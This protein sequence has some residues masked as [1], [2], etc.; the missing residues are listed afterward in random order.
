MV[1]HGYHTRLAARRRRAEARLRDFFS[2]ARARR[3]LL[4]E[5]DPITLSPVEPPLFVHVDLDTGQQTC[6]SAGVLAQY[7]L[8]SGDFRNPLTRKPLTRADLLRLQHAS[9]EPVFDEL[10]LSEARRKARQEREDLLQWLEGEAMEQ[11]DALV[12]ELGRARG[13]LSFFR[14]TAHFL[15]MLSAGVERVRAQCDERGAELCERAAQAIAS[16][17]P[18]SALREVCL[19]HVRGMAEEARAGRRVDLLPVSTRGPSRLPP[20]S[21]FSLLLE[22]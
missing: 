2:A 17:P 6:F 19:G 11:V 10:E 3:A 22:E 8:E 15:P 18:T 7:V 20:S 16:D 9:G 5:T 14:I 13:G 1:G 21:L 12:A 4:A